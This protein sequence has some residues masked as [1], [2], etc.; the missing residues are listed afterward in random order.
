ML[1]EGNF[2]G[3]QHVGIPVVDIDKTQKWYRDILGFKLVHSHAV[4]VE[5]GEVKLAFL[6][7]G[8]LQVKLYQL[9]GEALEEIKTRGNGHIDHF[10]I[11][12]LDVEKAI[13]DV[14]AAGAV[15]DKDTPDGSVPNPSWPPDGCK[16]VFLKSPNGEKVEFNQRLGLDPNRRKE[17]LGG[18]AHLGIPTIDYQQIKAFYEQFGFKEIMYVNIPVGDE[19]IHIIM[20]E[21]N[22]FILEF[23]QLFGNDLEEI[24]TRKDG[25]IDH[26]TF[27]VLDIDQ[28]YQELKAAGLKIL[29]DKPIFLRGVWGKGVKY[30]F[31]RG[32]EGEKIEF[33]QKVH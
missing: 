17:N 26:I 4:P 7:L 14:L 31:I 11:D 8:G 29:V 9:I 27:G 25:Y 18:W 23:Y 6:E 28:A 19:K 3:V 24:R 12:V 10:T 5:G 16:Y 20:V 33:N 13:N 2:Q 32:P 30:F 22:G 15:L 1:L 21:K